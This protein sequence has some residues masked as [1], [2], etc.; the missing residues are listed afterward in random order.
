MEYRAEVGLLTRNIVFQ[1][2]YDEQ[3]TK[4]LHGA[5]IMLFSDGDEESMGRIEYIEVRNAGQSFKL[6]RYPIHFHMIGNV[7][8]SYITGCAIHHTF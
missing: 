7:M 6:G 3:S 5:H 1:G 4:E 8:N 2:N